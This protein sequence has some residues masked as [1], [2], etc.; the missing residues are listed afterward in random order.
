WRCF[1]VVVDGMVFLHIRERTTALA[2]SWDGLSSCSRSGPRI[3]DEEVALGFA[4]AHGKCDLERIKSHFDH[5][6]HILILID[7]KIDL[8][9]F[10]KILAL[11]SL[12]AILSEAILLRE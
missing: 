1:E 12:V 2:K 6:L 5:R 7:F 8:R 10:L 11:A 4:F 3:R 9:W